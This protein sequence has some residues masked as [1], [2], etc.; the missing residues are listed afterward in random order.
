MQI[1][2]SD[3]RIGTIVS[4]SSLKLLH[5]FF[6]QCHFVFLLECPRSVAHKQ[7]VCGSSFAYRT[8]QPVHPSP[9]VVDMHLELVFPVF[10]RN[11]WDDRLAITAVPIN[12]SLTY[13]SHVSSPCAIEDR[14]CHYTWL[15]HRLVI[16]ASNSAPLFV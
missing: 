3:S 1:K 6:L 10:I 7:G 2:I 9:V 12:T 8:R 11:G 5:S 16:S 4:L 15:G 13:M 14:W